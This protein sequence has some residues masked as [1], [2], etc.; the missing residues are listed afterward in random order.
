MSENK[1]P[2]ITVLIVSY[3][4]TDLLPDC[5]ARVSFADEILH[6]NLDEKDIDSTSIV[7]KAGGRTIFHPRVEIADQVREYGMRLARNDW[8]WFVDPDERILPGLVA[9]VNRTLASD[10]GTLATILVPYRTFFNGKEL[11]G[12]TFGGEKFFPRIVHRNRIIMSDKVH[13]ACPPKPGM[14]TIRI[15]FNSVNTC[16]DH[17]WM[18]SWGQFF[19][20]QQRYLKHEGESQYYRGVRFSWKLFIKRP[21]RNFYDCI[22]AKQG[23]RDGL[24]GFLISCYWLW[25]SARRLLALRTYEQNIASRQNGN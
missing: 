10:D 24:T 14:C 19:E 13:T 5:L 12:T 18:R 7:N 21:L 6:I 25:Y 2:L 16:V 22:V 15:E 9:E 4:E 3:H 1:R 23:Y 20:K 8:I 17:L 11:R